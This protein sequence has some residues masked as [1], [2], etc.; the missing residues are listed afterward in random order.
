MFVRC[1]K[2]TDWWRA[3][4]HNTPRVG[5]SLKKLLGCGVSKW[6]TLFVGWTKYSIITPNTILRF[7]INNLRVSGTELPYNAHNVS[8]NR[9]DSCTRYHL[10][11]ALSAKK[12]VS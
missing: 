6:Y 8:D 7:F 3:L 4:N 1:L 2:E 12:Q 11:G 9:F 10:I 5:S